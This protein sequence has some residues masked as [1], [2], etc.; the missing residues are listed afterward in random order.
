MLEGGL[1]VLNLAP[2][3]VTLV[4]IVPGD[5]VQE[6]VVLGRRGARLVDGAGTRAVG[7]K[8]VEDASSDRKVGEGFGAKAVSG[9]GG[10]ELGKAGAGW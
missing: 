2:G 1:G 5:V 10:R 9:L 8:V 3:V 7:W 6:R 4:A